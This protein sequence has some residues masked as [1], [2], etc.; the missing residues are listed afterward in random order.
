[1]SEP[2]Q[3]KLLVHERRCAR[4]P[5][6]APVFPRRDPPRRSPPLPAADAEPQGLERG[7]ARKVG[8]DREAAAQVEAS[9]N[10][11]FTS[12]GAPVLPSPLPFSLEEIRLDELYGPPTP[13]HVKASFVSQR[14]LTERSVEVHAG[15]VEGGTR[16]SSQ[17][18]RR[19]PAPRASLGRIPRPA[20]DPSRVHF[21]T[22]L[23]QVQFVEADLFEGKRERRR[24]DGRTFARERAI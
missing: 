19:F 9:Q 3:P 10:C 5:F 18:L 17:H 1:L 4:P 23:C 13:F 8:Q 24:E 15:R 12:E 11:S 14:L 7:Q 21:N 2:A 6:A 16:N 22:T 20:F